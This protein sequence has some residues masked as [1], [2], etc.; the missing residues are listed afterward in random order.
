MVTQADIAKETKVDRTSVSKILC[1]AQLEHFSDDIVEKVKNAAI[2]LGYKHR[3]FKNALNIV[4]LFPLGADETLEGYTC[5]ERTMAALLGISKAIGGTKHHLQIVNIDYSRETFD[6]EI[7]ANT[8]DVF[9]IWELSWEWTNPFYELLKKK[10]KDF[11]VI[12]RVADNFQGSFIIHESDKVYIQNAIDIFCEHGHTKIAGVFG[13]VDMAVRLGTMKKAFNEKGLDYSTRNVF[14]FQLSDAEGCRKTAKLIAEGGFTAVF[15]QSNDMNALD[16][17]IELG[18]RG[19]RVPDDISI[20]GNHK[21]WSMP[22][23]GMDLSS[24]ETPWHEMGKKATEFLIAGASG[25]NYSDRIIQEV[26]KQKF[27]KGNTIRRLN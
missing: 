8:A 13:D 14:S 11:V 23:L 25:N 22:S 2:R 24:F 27:Y 7:V 21:K 12:N 16:L 5:A 3:N 18:K 19:L 26:L 9:I 20:L 6:F 4:F 1:G 10:K 17:V 15:V